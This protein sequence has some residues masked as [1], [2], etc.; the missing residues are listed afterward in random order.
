MESEKTVHAFDT[1]NCK[2][3]IDYAMSQQMAVYVMANTLA[4]ICKMP[5]T[6]VRVHKYSN[7]WNSID[8]K[9]FTCYIFTFTGVYLDIPFFRTAK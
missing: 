1:G 9:H 7:T 4:S 2:T 5:G 6:V 8:L 3:N